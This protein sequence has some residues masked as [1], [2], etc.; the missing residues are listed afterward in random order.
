MM[1]DLLKYLR[2][3]LKFFSKMQGADNIDQNFVEPLM[4]I[5]EE[6]IFKQSK[7]NFV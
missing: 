3:K 2:N 1:T 6:R 4:T 7:S 5:F